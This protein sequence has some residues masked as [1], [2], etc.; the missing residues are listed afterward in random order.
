MNNLKEIKNLNSINN[1]IHK[2]WIWGSKE[3][4]NK[5]CD[6]LQKI[7]YSIQDLNEEI[8]CLSNPEMKDVVFIISLVD[9]IKEAYSLIEKEL[10]NSLANDFAFSNQFELDA[11]KKYFEALRSF[12]VA[13]PMNTT[14]HKEFNFDGDFIC[15]DIQRFVQTRSIFFCNTFNWYCLDYLGLHKCVEPNICDMVLHAYSGKAD[16]NEFFQ[17]I[18]ID[19]KDIYHVAELYI[20]KLYELARYLSKKKKKDYEVNS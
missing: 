6:Y 12:V 3:S 8:K 20:D 5:S 10:I 18:G 4:Y 13:H 15:V 9:W 19:F 11:S 17:F 2:K 7:N 16:G 14:R 1:A